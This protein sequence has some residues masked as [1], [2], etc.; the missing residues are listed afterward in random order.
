MGA[1]RDQRGLNQRIA[2][3]DNLPECDCAAA[4]PPWPARFGWLLPVAVALLVYGVALDNF[5]AFDDFIWLN[6]AR[7]FRQD[8]LQIF[9]P[10]VTYFDPLVHLLFLLDWLVAGVDER[11]YH[12]VDLAIHAGNAVLVYRLALMLGPGP[13]PALYAGIFFAGSFA[14]ADA[15][16]W[17]SSRVDLVST[18]FSLA[19][20]IQFLLFLRQGRKRQLYLSLFLFLLALC[21]KGTPLVLPGLL[22][23]LLLQERKPLRS[24]LYLVPFGAVVLLFL[25][26]LKLN[27]HQASLPLDQLHFS[28]RNLA[29]SFC[30]LFIPEAA[31]KDAD[32][33]LVGSVLLL[34]VSAVGLVRIS[35]DRTVALRR[36]GCL[37]LA[38]AL[39]PVLVITE[40]K[41]VGE[42]SDPS[43]VLVSPSH[44]IYL[45]SVGAALLAGG[46]LASLE[47]LVGRPWP[48]FA[49]VAVLVVLSG[50]V[51]LGAYLVRERDRLWE[52]VGERSR[53]AYQGLVPYRG[54]VPEGSQI[55]LIYFPGSSGF[56]TPMVR[57]ALELDR[58]SIL[59]TVTL[60]VITDREI[61]GKA[62]SSYLFVL[63][64]GGKVHD[65]SEL[66]RQQLVLNRMVLVFP[67][68]PELS[69]QCHE[70]ADRLNREIGSL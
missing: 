10:D 25:L 46:F 58:V 30:A 22:L 1:E 55:G 29:L 70:V 3:E 8:W 38:L 44:R 68:R 57:L 51:V 5:F 35:A 9:R 64:R 11:W 4:P 56:T 15:V 32:L 48:R 69:S 17:S 53:A 61:L 66:Y 59:K 6:R 2:G 7:T 14:I 43:L 16:L 41:P 12:G 40:L 19:A 47:R 52:G 27:M 18:L 20:L 45:A 33:T 60:G 31:L 36:T 37:L 39:L 62:E 67:D 63:D 50:V 54:K 21:A 49:R 65:L 23:W 34:V 13:K 28:I 24:A 26:L 42:F